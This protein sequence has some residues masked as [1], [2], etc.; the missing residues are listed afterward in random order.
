M[1]TYAIRIPGVLCPVDW[2]LMASLWIYSQIP[3]NKKQ[4]SEKWFFSEVKDDNIYLY[5]LYLQGYTWKNQ[6]LIP[7]KKR[8]NN[9]I[10]K[11][12]LRKYLGGLLSI[13]IDEA[14]L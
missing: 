14:D 8:A 4:L 7:Q 2:F 10:E 9:F 13:I 5:Q 12:K 3:Q 6:F 11:G 1:G